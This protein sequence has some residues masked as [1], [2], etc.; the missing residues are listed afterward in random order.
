LV[1]YN[2]DNNLTQLVHKFIYNTQDFEYNLS[3]EILDI[4]LYAFSILKKNDMYND[5]DN[6]M[7]T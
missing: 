2:E 6:D 7:Y 1:I 4:D 5:Q 3:K